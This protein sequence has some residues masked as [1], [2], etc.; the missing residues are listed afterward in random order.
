MKRILLIAFALCSYSVAMDYQQNPQLNYT[1]YLNMGAA[2]ISHNQP[3][4]LKNML[5]EALQHLHDIAQLREQLSR[6]AH[7]VGKTECAAILKMRDL[8][9]TVDDNI[10]KALQ[11]DDSKML[12]QML[13]PMKIKIPTSTSDPVILAPIFDL[14]AYLEKLLK[15][16]QILKARHCILEICA[17]HHSLYSSSLNQ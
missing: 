10:F 7:Y 3:Y 8:T 4:Y 1:Y 16:A 5:Q 12:Q 17:F 2:L 15:I 13:A 14:E 9:T 6:Y 11:Q